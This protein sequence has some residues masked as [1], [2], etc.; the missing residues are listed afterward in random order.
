M[1]IQQ[2]SGTTDQNFWT[3]I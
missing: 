3:G 2:H 1:Q